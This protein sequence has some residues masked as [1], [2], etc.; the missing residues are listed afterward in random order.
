MDDTKALDKSDTIEEILYCNKKMVSNMSNSNTQTRMVDILDAVQRFHDDYEENILTDAIKQGYDINFNDI[1]KQNILFFSDIV[2]DAVFDYFVESNININQTNNKNENVLFYCYNNLHRTKK[3]L[4]YGINPLVIN[5]EGK[6][7]LDVLKQN[8]Q[9]RETSPAFAL[10][11]ERIK[12]MEQYYQLN[13]N[14]I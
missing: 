8:N 10:I 7:I 3:L 4:D 13:S 14:K 2:D 11:E 5:E 9:T 6:N 12:I 1:F